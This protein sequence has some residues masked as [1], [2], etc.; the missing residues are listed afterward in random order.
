M[1][2]IQVVCNADKSRYV[3]R[4][5]TNDYYSLLTHKHKLR[6]DKFEP[7]ESE[8]LKGFNKSLSVPDLDYQGNVEMNDMDGFVCETCGKKETEPFIAAKK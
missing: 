8:K 6:N 3:V 1:F 7:F 2:K 4:H 5:N